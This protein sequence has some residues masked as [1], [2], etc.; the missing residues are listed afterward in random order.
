MNRDKYNKDDK[1]GSSKSGSSKSSS[2]YESGSSN[3]GGSSSKYAKYSSS[4]SPTSNPSAAS[5]SS[6]SSS[7][8]SS[9]SW[10]FHGNGYLPLE[11]GGRDFEA[12][13]QLAVSFARM[14]SRLRQDRQQRNEDL[15]YYSDPNN[16]K[17]GKR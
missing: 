1:S 10:S 9:S 7:A 14:Q 5:S 3:Y 6:S 11:Y 8:S 16:S 12:S 4:S 2:K 17:N 15:G 13:A